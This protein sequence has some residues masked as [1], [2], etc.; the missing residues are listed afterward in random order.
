MEVIY[1]TK[2]IDRE[3]QISLHLAKVLNL[4]LAMAQE[5]ESI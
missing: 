4:I 1:F 5:A 2:I 3:T